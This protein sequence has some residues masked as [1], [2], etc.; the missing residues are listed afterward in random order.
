VGFPSGGAGVRG[1]GWVKPLQGQPLPKPRPVWGHRLLPVKPRREREG[2]PCPR[3]GA[4][5][6]M[7]VTGA[8]PTPWDPNRAVDPQVPRD[9]KG[10]SDSCDPVVYWVL[11]LFF[12][13]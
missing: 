4:G 3:R 6:S 13:K 8:L 11:D 1:A 5:P 7:R 9:R 2:I 12:T 10:S